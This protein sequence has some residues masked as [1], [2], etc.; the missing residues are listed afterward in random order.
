MEDE[1]RLLA[2]DTSAEKNQHAD[3]QQNAFSNMQDNIMKMAQSMET[4]SQA[5]AQTAK[6]KATAFKGAREKEKRAKRSHSREPST[7]KQRRS[8]YSKSEEDSSDDAGVISSSDTDSESETEKLVTKLSVKEKPSAKAP[9]GDCSKSE[10][11]AEIEK[12][13]ETNDKGLEVER[14]VAKNVIK[15]WAQRMDIGILKGKIEKYPAP[16]NCENLMAPRVNVPVWK[17]LD[18]YTKSIDIRMV[19]VQ[20]TCVA[21][22]PALAGCLNDLVTTNYVDVPTLIRHI[23]DAV[24][25]DL[26]INP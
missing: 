11:K 5:W 10:L 2:D 18:R 8:K 23:S 1:D 16:A 9:K 14:Q 12:E 26:S 17:T 15:R 22:G 20:K 3:T 24:G 13:F 7:S 25:L 6:D 21:A 4:M 19:N